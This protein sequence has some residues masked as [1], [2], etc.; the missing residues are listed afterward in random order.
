MRSFSFCKSF[1]RSISFFTHMTLSFFIHRVYV[2]FEWFV[3]PES[4]PRSNIYFNFI[5]FC[6]IAP[7]QVIATILRLIEVFLVHYW[8][9]LSFC[10]SERRQVDFVSGENFTVE[11]LFRVNA[12]YSTRRWYQSPKAS[13][14]VLSDNSPSIQLSQARSYTTS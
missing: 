9:L 11:W 7:M 8:E 10:S 4:F 3:P 12:C 6:G 14:Y 13:M 5:L 1:L 2:F